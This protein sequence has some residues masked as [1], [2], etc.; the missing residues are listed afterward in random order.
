MALIWSRIVSDNG[1]SLSIVT[2]DGV[3]ISLR[4]DHPSFNLVTLKLAEGAPDCEILELAQPVK[5]AGQKLQRLSE[6][7]TFDG[8][9][10]RLDGDPIENSLGEYIVGLLKTEGTEEAISWEPFVAFLE[11]LAQNTNMDSR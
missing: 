11:K 5:R 9:S 7:I 3:T 10:I 1:V 6:R 8:A 2:E 4:E